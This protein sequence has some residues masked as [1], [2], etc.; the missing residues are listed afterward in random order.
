MTAGVTDYANMNYT[1]CMNGT[2]SATPMVAGVAALVLQANPNLGWR[3]VRVILA[4]TARKNDP[5]NAEWKTNGA[6][7]NYN[8]NYGFGVVDASRAVT[9]AMTWTNLPAE[10]TY[11]TPVSSPNL[12]IPDAVV[13]GVT[14]TL[15]VTDTITV[16]G[17]GITQIEFVEITFSAADH[18]YSGDLEITIT[19]PAGTVSLLAETHL[20]DSNPCAT[21]YSG[22]IFGST[23]FLGESADG[24]WVLNVRDN[25]PVDT[26]HF[27]SWRL[28]FHGN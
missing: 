5:L 20:C 9:S 11:A 8:P 6:G 15:S 26:G 3:D 10:K 27:Q 24:N 13:S 14:N 7:I 25:A 17:S 4:K 16:T 12:A 21:S 19:S 23:N 22:W 28:K 2:S 1:K 18:P